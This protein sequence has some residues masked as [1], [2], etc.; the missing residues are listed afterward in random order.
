M[1]IRGFSNPLCFWQIGYSHSTLYCKLFSCTQCMQ[2]RHSW[3]WIELTGIQLKNKTNKQKKAPKWIIKKLRFSLRIRFPSLQEPQTPPR[4]HWDDMTWHPHLLGP[5]NTNMKCGHHVVAL[6]KTHRIRLFYGVLRLYVFPASCRDSFPQ[7]RFYVN[8][9]PCSL[10]TH[11]SVWFRV[12][13][14]CH[15]YISPF[16]SN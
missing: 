13:T 15:S 5:V 7:A 6:N 1:D 11:K 3:G 4:L 12:S 16:V 14:Q 9:V 8:N 2:S 10:K